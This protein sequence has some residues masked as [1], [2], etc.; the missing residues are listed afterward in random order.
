MF[1]FFR[2]QLKNQKGF[3][4]VELMVVVVIIGILIAIAVPAYNK[5]TGNAE[6]K[7]CQANQRTIEGAIRM[8]NADSETATDEKIT[9]GKVNLDVLV[10]AGYL[11][12]T[13]TCPLD[14]TYSVDENGRVSCDV[15]AHNPPEGTGGGTGSGGEGG[16]SG[17]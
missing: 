9:T 3:T 14:G 17:S 4:L 11:T 6:A 15:A 5:V 2:K 12:E 13:P 7:A 16:G 10:K 8:Y 1:K